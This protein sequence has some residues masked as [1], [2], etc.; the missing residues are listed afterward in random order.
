[1][2]LSCVWYMLSVVYADTLCSYALHCLT[3]RYTAHIYCSLSID[4]TYTHTYMMHTTHTHTLHSTLHTYI[5]YTWSYTGIEDIKGYNSNNRAY[6][7]NYCAENI[8]IANNNKYPRSNKTI[9][10]DSL[11]KGIDTW[12]IYMVTLHGIYVHGAMLV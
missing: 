8:F 5:I 6:K 10:Y 2:L 12:S 11:Y 3:L 1:M 9:E 7:G 4:N